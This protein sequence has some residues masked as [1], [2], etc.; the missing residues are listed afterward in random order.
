MDSLYVVQFVTYSVRCEP[1][2]RSTCALNKVLLFNW[3]FQCH[4][5]AHLKILT[6]LLTP[7]IRRSKDEVSESFAANSV[8]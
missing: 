6:S 8:E 5:K 7:W 1:L 4:T 3:E 2:I